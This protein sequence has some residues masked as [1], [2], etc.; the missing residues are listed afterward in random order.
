MAKKTKKYAGKTDKEWRD[1]GE[2]F[3]KQMDKVA[4]KFSDRM[5][6]A[7]RNHR[8]KTKKQIRNDCC[9]SVMTPLFG[10][11]IQVF[12]L[13]V[14]LWILRSINFLNISLITN[15]YL[16]IT[17]NLHWFFA[18]F[19]VFGYDKYAKKTQDNYWVVSPLFNSFRIVFSL[20]IVTLVIE[21]INIY[22]FNSALSYLAIF[23]YS[24]TAK[25]F[26]TFLIL[27]YV[28]AF[29]GKIIEVNKWHKK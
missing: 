5:E 12:I 6:R 8:L 26:I 27:L 10:A 13:A 22:T 7:G 14:G 23:F 19:L 17:S 1:L 29:I 16:I 24:N 21:L 9:Y 2:E 28:A 3:G 18:A 25:I 15:F 11:A 20:W 4:V